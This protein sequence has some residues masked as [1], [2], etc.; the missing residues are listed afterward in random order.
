MHSNSHF[1]NVIWLNCLQTAVLFPDMNM[2]IY[3]EDNIF[4]V[5]VRG[6]G[7]AP[8]MFSAGASASPTGPRFLRPWSVMIILDKSENDVRTWRAKFLLTRFGLDYLWMYAPVASP[9]VACSTIGST[10]EVACSPK[11]VTD[12]VKPGCFRRHNQHP[13]HQKNNDTNGNSHL[14]KLER[15]DTCVQRLL[16]GSL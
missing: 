6:E 12:R 9:H 10:N 2:P 3:H 14:R 5:R 8:R 1:V 15:V 7:S 13:S 4:F 16:K 11:D